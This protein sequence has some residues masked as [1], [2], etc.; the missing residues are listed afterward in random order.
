MYLF[1]LKKVRGLK[2]ILKGVFIPI[3]GEGAT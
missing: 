3:L 1:N 2:P